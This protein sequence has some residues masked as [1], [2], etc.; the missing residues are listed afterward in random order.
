MTTRAA[1]LILSGGAVLFWPLDV[2]A[3]EIPTIVVVLAAAPLLA[4]VLSIVL[5]TMAKSWSIGLGNLGLVGLWIAWFAA[6]SF[7]LTS[8]L[9]TWAPIAAL[10]IHVVAIVCLIVLRALRRERTRHDA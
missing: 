2:R 5:G 1:T 9:M 8:D 4:I 7:Y 6:A 10:A 3:Q